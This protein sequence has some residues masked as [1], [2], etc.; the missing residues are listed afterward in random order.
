MFSQ[1]S[2][3][4][5]ASPSRLS[6]VDDAQYENRLAGRGIST[7]ITEAWP[8]SLSPG[9]EPG[10]YCS[11]GLA[12]ADVTGSR[13][14]VGQEPRGGRADRTRL[15]FARKRL[16]S[17]WRPRGR[18]MR[19]AMEPLVVRNGPTARC[20][21]TRWDAFASGNLPNYGASA[22]HDLVVGRLSGRRKPE[23]GS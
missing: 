16:R 17:S 8:E 13:N 4:R 12:V 19:I 23:T 22:S 1:P 3:A 21:E 5:M 14:Y 11:A 15:I 18:S 20:A 7:F 6:T 2:L 9:N 10:D